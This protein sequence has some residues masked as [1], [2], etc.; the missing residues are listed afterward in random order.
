MFYSNKPVVFSEWKNITT[1][2]SSNVIKFFEN[3]TLINS[4]P[5]NSPF[6]RNGNIFSIGNRFVE[7]ASTP[8]CNF[9]IGKIDD[10]RIYNRALTQEEITYLAN[11]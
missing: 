8:A 7:N 6:I 11:N 4:I 2:I 5:F 10:V 9:F 3:G 1:V